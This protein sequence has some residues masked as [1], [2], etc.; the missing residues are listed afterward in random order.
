MVGAESNDMSE[1][2]EEDEPENSFFFAKKAKY[3]RWIF[4]IWSPLTMR[5][6]STTKV[7]TLFSNKF[8]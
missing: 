7:I 5:S 6:E 8:Y 1:G 3:S 4:S 2:S